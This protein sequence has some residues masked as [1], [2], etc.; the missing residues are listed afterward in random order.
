MS[1]Y[2]LQKQA[3][4]EDYRKVRVGGKSVLLDKNIPLVRN[5]PAGSEEELVAA[6]K[7]HIA[8]AKPGRWTHSQIAIPATIDLAKLTGAQKTRLAI[9]LPGERIGAVSTRLGRLHSHERGPVQLVHLDEHAPQTGLRARVEHVPETYRSA[10]KRFLERPAPFV[11][12]AQANKLKVVYIDETGAGHRSQ[13]NNVVRAARKMGIEAEAVDFTDT[14]LKKKTTGKEYRKAY[15]NYLSKKNL[16]SVPRLAKAHLAYHGGVDAKKKAKFLAENKDSAILL[17]HPHLEFQFR[18]V[19]KPV[20]VMHTDPVK[21]PLSIPVSSKGT[22]LHIG[23]S[24][25]VGDMKGNKKEV[26][27]L[28]VHPDLLRKRMKRSGLMDKKKFNVTV[29][30]GGEALEVPEMVEQILQ[31]DLPENAEIHAV[32]GRRKDVLKKLQRMAKKDSRL[33]PHGFAPLP[34]MMREADLNVIRAHGT[35]YAETLT[36]GKPAVYYGPSRNLIDF[37][38]ALTRRTAVHGGKRTSYPVAVGLEEIPTALSE[39]QRNYK[40]LRQRAK[41]LQKDYG[42]PASQ[43]AATAVKHARAPR[44]Y[45]KEYNEYHS[46]PE[47]VANRS[48]RNQAR[49][50][51][52]LKNGDSRE[53]DHKNPLSKGGSNGK[54]NLR[55]V[56]RTEN[57]R[58]FDGT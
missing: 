4:V 16:S 45:K 35:S 56:S 36:S 22:R 23:S 55:A 5:V 10:K 29:S 15:L 42:D 54:G 9:P 39:A 46:R 14:F 3:A 17:A 33:R 50:K 41:A 18:D 48:L 38:G 12:D 37:Q 13:A 25:V 49:R 19:K 31:S 8:K 20:S 1:A 52:G 6:L 7:E 27:G 57:R 24:G 2:K 53:V 30:A 34:K 40:G 58:K 47:Q 43:I 51:L 44:D 26:S 28:A 11:K 21:W 32:A